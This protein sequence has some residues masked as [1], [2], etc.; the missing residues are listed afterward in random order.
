MNRIELNNL[1]QL[2]DKINQSYPLL[3]LKLINGMANEKFGNT[4][5]QFLESNTEY[6]CCGTQDYVRF[7]QLELLAEE[8]MDLQLPGVIA[9]LGVYQGDF[10]QMI[11]RLFPDKILYLFD[12]FK[13]FSENQITTE[14]QSSLVKDSFINR[15]DMYLETSAEKVLERM[16]YPSN[17][18]IIKGTFPDTVTNIE[19]QYC[20]VS[21]DADFY[22][23]TLDGLK[24]F[25]PRMVNGGYIMVHDY[26]DDEL[27]GVKKAIKEYRKIEPSMKYLP[28]TDS[29]GTVIII[30]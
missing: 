29:F 21:I 30:K 16:K 23:V 4:L 27:F 24:Y 26:N 14:V 18:K 9:E 7:R 13:G 10:A 11:N 3:N 17:C 12:T 25:Y 8:I 15:I 1:Y 6:I 22:Q 19:E 20:F 5:F 28:I 2:I